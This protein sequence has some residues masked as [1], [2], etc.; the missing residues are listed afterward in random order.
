MRVYLAG[1]EVFHKDAIGLGRRKIE[2]CARFGLQG[3]YP[4]DPEKGVAGDDKDAQARWIFG[5]N[6]ALI[7]GAE[8]CIANISPFKGLDCDPGTA[9]EIAY[10]YAAG[11]RV[12]GYTADGGALLERDAALTAS[13]FSS[14]A[15]LMFPQAV[16][17]AEDFDR[18][19]NLMI[20]ESILA[21]GGFIEA[22]QGRS[23]DD[24]GVFERLVAR[25]AAAAQA[26]A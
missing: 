9:W 2:I 25:I 21:S 18:P 8:A 11:K 13:A 5:H 1:P 10:C 3:L 12:Y 7:D 19:T 14:D 20:H 6:V 22:A 15:E 16:A 23:F 26:K 17:T 24:L 4:I